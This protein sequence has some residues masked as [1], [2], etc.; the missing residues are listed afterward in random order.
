MGFLTRLLIPRSVRRAAHPTR[1]VKSALT[2]KSIKQARRALHPLDN[3]AYGVAR[4]LNTKKPPRK[5]FYRHGT[6][7]MRHRSP[8]AAAKCR[9]SF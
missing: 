1:T 9:R 6:C 8:E 7:T 2:P 4:S 3:A 5:N